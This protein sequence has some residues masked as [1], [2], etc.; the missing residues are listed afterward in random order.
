MKPKFRVNNFEKSV[1]RIVEE[2]KTSY[3]DA[4]LIYC[5]ENQVDPD[6]VKTLMTPTIKAKLESEY[7][8]LNMLPKDNELEF[9]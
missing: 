9:E 1:L 2:K 4:V 8:T 6:Y 7:K 5:E 3:I